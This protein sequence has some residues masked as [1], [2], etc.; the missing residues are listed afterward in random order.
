MIHPLPPTVGF[1]RVSQTT[2]DQGNLETQ[3]RQLQEYGV[4][5][6]VTEIGSGARSDRQALKGLCAGRR[7]PLSSM[8]STASA[9]GP[10]TAF[11]SSG[12]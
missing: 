1:A 7:H 11:A 2:K 4:H 6:V 8:P 12:M 5:E 9:G 3:T 10:W